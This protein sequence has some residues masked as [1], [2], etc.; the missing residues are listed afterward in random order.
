MIKPCLMQVMQWME[1][2][3]TH[4]SNVMYGNILSFAQKS[5]GTEYAAVIQE[6]V[7]MIVTPAIVATYHV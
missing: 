7:G 2:A 4:P 6:R 5:V 3:G 1:D